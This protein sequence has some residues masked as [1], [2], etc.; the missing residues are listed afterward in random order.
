MV[1]YVAVHPSSQGSIGSSAYKVSEVIGLPI[2]PAVTSGNVYSY[3][4]LSSLGGGVLGHMV[5][6]SSVGLRVMQTGTGTSFG[7]A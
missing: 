2:T 3:K 5:A 7:V 6:L 4:P 1:N